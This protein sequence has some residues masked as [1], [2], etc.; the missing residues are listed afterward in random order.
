MV[1]FEFPAEYSSNFLLQLCFELSIVRLFFTPYRAPA[2]LRSGMRTGN[3]K[4]AFFKQT[5][6][7]KFLLGGAVSCLKHPSPPGVS[8]FHYGRG[9]R[10][11]RGVALLHPTTFLFRPATLTNPHPTRP[12]SAA[13]SKKPTEYIRHVFHCRGRGPRGHDLIGVGCLQPQW[14]APATVQAT[15]PP[16]RVYPRA[17][18]A[19]VEGAARRSQRYIRRLPEE[20]EAPGSCRD[21][22]AGTNTV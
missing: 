20:S 2:S 17:P 21:A 7:P 15:P 5:P 13:L 6:W 4:G 18:A 19:S 1:R 9:C 12:S 8:L 11:Q 14:R 22:P 16:A 3:T 10:C